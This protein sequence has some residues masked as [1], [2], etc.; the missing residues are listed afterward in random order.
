MLDSWSAILGD[1]FAAL[2][3]ASGAGVITNQYS[4]R[5]KRVVKYPD[6]GCHFALKLSGVSF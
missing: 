3:G 6:T 4:V 2:E 5:I 1:K